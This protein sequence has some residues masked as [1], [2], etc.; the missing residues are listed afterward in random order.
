M[1]LSG[2]RGRVCRIGGRTGPPNTTTEEKEVI[3][4]STHT[5][6]TEPEIIMGTGSTVVI[7]PSNAKLRPAL[8]VEEA[9]LLTQEI[10]R[11][12]ARL[13]IL[14]TEAHDRQAHTA[15]GYASWDDYVRLEFQMSPSRSYQLLDT[16]HVMREL[17][18]AGADIAH[19]DPP[20][21]RVVA[22]VK[23]R[24]SEIRSNVADA[25]EKGHDVDKVLRDMARTPR[26][27]SADQPAPAEPAELAREPEGGEPDVVEGEVVKPAAKVV[28]VTCPAC[29]GDGKVTRSLANRLRAFMKDLTPK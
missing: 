20:P 14:V 18:V 4:M 28:T 2:K 27:P 16:G 24:L 19:M 12:T 5:A 9:R 26:T 13:W 23:N 11:T 8:D 21:A 10:R 6:A 15:M 3:H 29:D 1:C 7:D 22:R 25:L 17:A